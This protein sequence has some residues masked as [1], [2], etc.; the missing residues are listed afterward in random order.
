MTTRSHP[1]LAGVL[2]LAA[3]VALGEARPALALTMK[4]CSDK[5]KAARKDGTLGAMTWTEFRRAQCGPDASS[6]VKPAGKTPPAPA[7]PTAGAPV[8][9]SAISPKYAK[10]KPGKARMHTCLDQYHANKASNANGGL[11]WIKKGGGYY[12]ECNRRL[13]G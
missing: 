7:A 1:V 5:F 4:E 12:S 6:A 13:K 8:F 11:A 9:P 2:V 3:V 10:E